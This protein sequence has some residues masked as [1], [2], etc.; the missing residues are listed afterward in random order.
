MNER[1]DLK[2]KERKRNRRSRIWP[3][4]LLHDTVHPPFLPLQLPHW[5]RKCNGCVFLILL[6]AAT[7]RR[8][9]IK[10][11]VHLKE[12]QRGGNFSSDDEVN[13]VVQTYILAAAETFILPENEEAGGKITKKSASTCRWTTWIILF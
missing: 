8:A 1:K 10:S 2:G 12:A 5:K 11:S 13:E 9:I 7:L 6:T 4:K 3:V